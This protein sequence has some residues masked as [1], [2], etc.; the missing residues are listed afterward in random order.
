MTESDRCQASSGH[1]TAL[2]DAVL[3]ESLEPSLGAPGDWLFGPPV[4]SLTLQG[5]APWPEAG[6]L[7]AQD[8]PDSFLQPVQREALDSL[9]HIPLP[10]SLQ[11]PGSNSSGQTASE[12]AD[13]SPYSLPSAGLDAK[14]E[15][16]RAKN[17]IAMRKHRAK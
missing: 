1:V 6:P 3:L 16:A 9:E 10:G 2:S 4:D 14:R 13:G 11:E 12:P 17:R 5:M 7:L 8:F 15:R